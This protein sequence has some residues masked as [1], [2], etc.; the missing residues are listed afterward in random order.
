MMLFRTPDNMVMKAEQAALD[1][2][3]IFNLPAKRRDTIVW[4]SSDVRAGLRG[5]GRVRTSLR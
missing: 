1:V 4:C 5:I 3:S 2:L